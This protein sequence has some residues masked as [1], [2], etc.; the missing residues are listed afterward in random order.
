MAQLL[1]IRHCQG[2]GQSP[3]APLTEAGL[4]QAERLAEFLQELEVDL[5]VSSP[6]RRALETIAPL[7]RQRNL[8]VRQE[9]RLREREL[10]A[11]PLP[12]WLEHIERS[13]TD[14]DYRH[15]TGES[16]R[17]AQERGWA[18]LDDILAG[19]CSLPAVVTH[20]N[21][22][23]LVL[24]RVDPSIGVEFWRGL[25]NPDV[26]RLE[27]SGSDAWSMRRIWRDAAR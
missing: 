16:G 14:P 23:A 11:G 1:L 25:T 8:P 17:A 6:Y 22:L 21:L 15:P 27:H 20:G 3:E 26:F 19:D 4:R 12:N 24:R 2:S 9:R 7:A 18:A 5:I 13:F 10:A